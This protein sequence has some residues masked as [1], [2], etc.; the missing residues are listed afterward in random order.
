MI[1]AII[2]L[3]ICTVLALGMIEQNDFFSSII[4]T[5]R[6]ENTDRFSNWNDTKQELISWSEHN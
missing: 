1:Y 6:S 5:N 4:K 2:E 3:I